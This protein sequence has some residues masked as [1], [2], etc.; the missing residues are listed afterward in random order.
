[1][2]LNYRNVSLVLKNLKLKNIFQFVF[3]KLKVNKN[4]GMRN[5]V[6]Y[7]KLERHEDKYRFILRMCYYRIKYVNKKKRHEMNLEYLKNLLSF[8]H[9]LN[10]K[11][12]HI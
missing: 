5:N 12:K 1:M 3:E 11:D 4:V 6:V 8:R 10:V 7:K 2:K 9:I